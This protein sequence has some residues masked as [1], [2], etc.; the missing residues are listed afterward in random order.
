[1]QVPYSPV[2]TATPENIATP[3]LGVSTPGAAF[4][5]TIGAA[6]SH[7]G[8][9]LGHAGD[10][11][12]RR[13][14][15]LQELQNETQA[16]EADAKYMIEAGKLHVQFS[17]LEGGNASPAALEKYTQDLDSLRKQ[18]RSDLPNDAAR[19][20]YDGSSLSTMGRTIFN[21]AGH[22]GQQQKVAAHNASTARIDS[23]KNWALMFPDDEV[24]F[25]RFERATIEET[26]AQAAVGGWDAAQTEDQI[27]KN[28]SSLWAHRLT[29]LAKSEPNRAHDLFEDNKET[30]HFNDRERVE[31]SINSQL[32]TV[33]AR[34]ISR[35]V[36]AD[37]LGGA[38]PTK[39]DKGL[40]ERLKEAEERAAKV[41]KDPLFA[42]AVRQRVRAD[43]DA[44]KK[45]ERDFQADNMNTIYDGFVGNFSNGKVP[46]NI[47]ELTADSRVGAAY[48]ALS[49]QKKLDVQ[50]Q[51]NRYNRAVTNERRT[52]IAVRRAEAKNEQADNMNILFD[53]IQGNYSQGQL[54]SNMRELLSN[55][56]VEEAYGALPAHKQIE[57]Q[58]QLNTYYNSS[59]KQAKQ[60]EYF[61]LAGLAQN[62]PGAFINEDVTKATLSQGDMKKLFT[63]Q[64]QMRKIPTEDPGVAEAMR[65]LRPKLEAIGLTRAKDEAG[66]NQFTGALQEVFN[67]YREQNKRPTGKDVDE[68]GTRLLQTFVTHQGWLYNT[69]EQVYKFAVPEA[70]RKEILADDRWKNLGIVP[71]EE[72]IRRS[73]I[74]LRYKELYGSSGTAP[75]APR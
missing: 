17:A 16:K 45:E 10:E 34:N 43:Y 65:T 54:P 44:H 5:E 23:M 48:D 64:R 14:M 70:F 72:L 19:K 2:P 66:Y 32:R 75:E 59:T 27:N 13:A 18:I 20:M 71:D 35:E 50:A 62:D 25:K 58:R 22:A 38:D 39:P 4:G 60:D 30:L 61:R 40:S 12:F 51:L 6:V 63:L 41:S 67:S 42:D 57:V 33:G 1:M 53:A 3:K 7:L 52:E 47:D 21:G 46:A 73:Y 68:I 29:G 56:T 26:K 15:A 37:L 9:Q 8:Q 49:P 11:I 31:Q 24:E 36:N 55:K 74:R 28:V 69:R